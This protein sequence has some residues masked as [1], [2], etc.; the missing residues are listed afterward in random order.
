M[1]LEL[2]LQTIAEE[3]SD[4]LHRRTRHCSHVTVHTSLFT[5]HRSH[6]TVRATMSRVLTVRSTS[7]LATLCILSSCRTVL[8]ASPSSPVTL[9]KKNSHVW[10]DAGGHH[11]STNTVTHHVASCVTC[12]VQGPAG[13]PHQHPA[14]HSVTATAQLWDER[15]RRCAGC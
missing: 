6:V 15:M 11:T 1:R 2:T 12:G 10:R 14:P 5:R 13:S 3:G 9:S 4:S 7:M 8:A